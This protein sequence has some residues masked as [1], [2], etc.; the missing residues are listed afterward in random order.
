MKKTLLVTSVLLL[1]LSVASAFGIKRSNFFNPCGQDALTDRN[2][3]GYTQ[4]YKGVP[5][6]GGQVIQHAFH[7]NIPSNKNNYFNVQNMSVMPGITRNAAVNAFC[8][9]L[10]NPELK[11]I[12]GYRKHKNGLV[13]FPVNIQANDFRLAYTVTLKTDRL[14]SLTGIVDASN[15]TVLSQFSTVKIGNEYWSYGL[16]QHYGPGVHGTR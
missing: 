14:H 13:I 15:G 5:I 3:S 2:G 6:F 7:T 4:Y 12:A 10:G 11:E 9:Y 1:G 8:A 16:G